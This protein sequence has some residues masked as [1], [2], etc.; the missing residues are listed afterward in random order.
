MLPYAADTVAEAC[1]AHLDAAAAARGSC[2]LA[3]P[4]GRTPG[5]VL[6]ALARIM[7]PFVRDRLHLLWLDERAV[8]VGH[9]DRND[10]PT[11][12]AWRAGGPL[13]RYV[14]PMPAELE[15]LDVAAQSYE[16]TLL[17]ATGGTGILD[18]ALI[19]IGEDGHLASLFPHH[20]GLKELSPVFVIRDSPKP[21]A[22]RLSV[23]LPVV[24]AA[25]LRVIL[26]LG[27]AKGAVAKAA[28]RG[29]DANLPVSLLPKEDTVWYL[30]DG[31]AVA[32]S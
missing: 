24:N 11:L 19:G 25:R 6:T 10:G 2:T 4:G 23:S 26:A 7:D 1:L 32:A 5:P 29:P 22:Y 20:Q 9:G 17:E 28:R 31:A 12:A 18:V 8:P 21:P 30:D 27:A 15:D 16:Q 3:I 13:P 14:H